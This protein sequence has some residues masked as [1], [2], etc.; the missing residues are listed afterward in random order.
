MKSDLDRLMQEAGLDAL[1]IT[2]PR[3]H[4]PS[5]TYFTGPAHLTSADLLKRRGQPPILFCRSMERDEAAATGM[6]TKTYIRGDAV[7]CS[8]IDW[9][10]LQCMATQDLIN[11]P[12]TVGFHPGEGAGKVIYTAFHQERQT[13]R[14]MD[15]ILE[16]LVFEL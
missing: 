11:V 9:I 2:G 5:L 12:F 10:L 15:T 14:D 4:N 16:L 3:A 6:Q 7:V 1:L 8:E 13:T